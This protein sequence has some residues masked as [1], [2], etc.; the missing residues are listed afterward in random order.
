MS[1][2]LA[3]VMFLRGE[4]RYRVAS[5]VGLRLDRLTD[6]VL[7]LSGLSGAGRRRWI[8]ARFRQES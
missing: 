3:A 4:G 2:R 5:L 6:E 8:P 1:E 7:L